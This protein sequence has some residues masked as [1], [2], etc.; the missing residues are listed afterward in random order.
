MNRQDKQT[1]IDGLKSNFQQSEA[2][3]LFGAKGMTVAQ[4]QGLRKALHAKGAHVQVAK[5]T[6]L[7]IAAQNIPGISDLDQYFKEQIGV[8]F[9]SK[10]A[11]AVAKI[12]CDMSKEQEQFAVV[13]GCMDAQ[14]IDKKTVK[15]LASLPSREVLLAQVC[16]TLQAPIASMV[17]VLKLASEK[18]Q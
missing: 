8:V 14:V 3:F 17:Y 12:L 7:K 18:Q 1:V 16:G 11:P 4:V 6:L 5:N 2:T 15:F 10:E 13:A 9:A